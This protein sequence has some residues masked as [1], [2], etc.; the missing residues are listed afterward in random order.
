MIG[1]I[2]I[3]V[4]ATTL[5]TVAFPLAA[6]RLPVG[7]QQNLQLWTG[8]PVG[9]LSVAVTDVVVGLALQPAVQ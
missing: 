7:A 5:L 2:A 9:D 1:N 3:S 6:A 4:T 8:R